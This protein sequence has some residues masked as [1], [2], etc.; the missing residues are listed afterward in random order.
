MTNINNCI[1]LKSYA[2]VNLYLDIIERLESSYHIIETIFQ[3]ISLCDFIYIKKTDQPFIKIRCNNPEIPL[4]EDSL[5]FRTI[6]SLVINKDIGLD[7]F[8]DKRIPLASGLG[9]GS[10]NAATMLLGINRLLNI[11]KSPS[12]LAEIAASLGMDIPYFLKRGTVYASEKGEKLFPIKAINPPL[13]MILINPGIRISTAWAYEMYDREYGINK[14][15][16]S[17]RIE[18][19]LKKEKRI[20]LENIH[21]VVYNC[22]EPTIGN[23]YPVIKKIKNQLMELGAVS[24]SLSGSGSTVFGVFEN[25]KMVNKAYVKIKH[26]YPFVEKAK[27]LSARNIYQ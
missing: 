10:S 9:G 27:T 19:Y 17:L 21:D 8:I 15:D 4:G 16:Y 22:F 3:T 18:E 26:K 12:K 6:E 7:I 11:K 5:I 14:R 13:N 2:K 24:V 25:Y 1:N 20:K 23:R